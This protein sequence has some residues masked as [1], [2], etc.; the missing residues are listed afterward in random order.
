MAFQS[1]FTGIIARFAEHTLNIV[2]LTG[3]EKQELQGCIKLGLACASAEALGVSTA[4]Y[5]D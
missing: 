3:A 5:N 2:I 1:M 4:N